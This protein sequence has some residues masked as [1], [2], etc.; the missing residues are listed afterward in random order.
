VGGWG[1]CGLVKVDEG[2]LLETEGEREIETEGREIV[3]EVA[4]LR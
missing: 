3:K 1:Q 2:V 4:I